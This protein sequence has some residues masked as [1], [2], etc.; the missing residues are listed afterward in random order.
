MLQALTKHNEIHSADRGHL[1]RLSDAHLDRRSRRKAPLRPFLSL[2]PPRVSWSTQ[3]LASLESEEEATGSNTGRT[4]VWT[5]NQKL[6]CPEFPCGLGIKNPAWWLWR[7][8]TA[9][10][11]IRP[12]AW[13][14]PYAVGAALEKTRKKKKAAWCL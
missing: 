2:P 6:Q 1:E 12:L 11:P 14:P 5:G 3:A 9:T 10:V 8:P 7:R 4:E 13:E